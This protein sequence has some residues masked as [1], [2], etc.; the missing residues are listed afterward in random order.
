MSDNT[1]LFVV[2]SGPPGSG[3]STIAPRL[4]TQLR[5][6]LVAKDTLKEALMSV[7]PPSDLEMSRTLGHA[8]IRA[9][10]AVAADSAPGAVLDGNFHRTAAADIARLPGTL[11][12]VFCRCDREVAAERYRSRATARHPGHFDTARTDEDLWNDEV[13]RPVAGGWPVL[14]VDTNRPVD[15][16]ALVAELGNILAG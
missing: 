8:A 2:V 6:P 1:A 5:L 11:V 16:E 3:K 13:A 7:L 4:A 10:F 14:D 12:E 15:V 9:M